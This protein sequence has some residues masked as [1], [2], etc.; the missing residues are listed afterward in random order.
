MKFEPYNSYRNC[1]FPLI[2]LIPENWCEQKIKFQLSGCVAGGTPESGNSLFWEESGEGTPWVSIAD[3]TRT[4]VVTETE[5]DVSDKGIYAKGLKIV[6]K[7]TLLYS[8]FASLGKV[9]EA[10]ADLTT[11]QAILA[12]IPKETLNNRF[13]RYWLQSI[14]NYLMYYSTSNTQNNLNSEK[15]KNLPVFVPSDLEQEK[16]ANFLD[17]ETAKID[18]LIEK[19]Q[20]LIRLLKEK[21]QAVISHAVTKGLSSLKGGPKAKM[22]D[23]GVEWLGEVPEHWGV[24]KVKWIVE[25][26]GRIGYRGYTVDDIVDEGDGAIVL[27]PSNINE[28][29]FSLEKKVFLSWGKY[30]ESPEIMLEPGDILLVKTSWSFG[31]VA[32]VFEVPSPMTINPQ[33]VLLKKSKIDSRYVSQFLGTD[34]LQA[35]IFMINTGSYMPTMTQENIGELPILV[36]PESEAIEIASFIQARCIKFNALLDKQE[37]VVDLLQER[38]AALI[39]AAVTGKID[40][41]GWVAP[42]S[43]Q[44]NKEV[45]A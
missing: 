40:V 6:P 15:V 28:R 5:K 12:L 30:F 24:S 32:V 7:G 16:I 44:T 38:R 4:A 42:G 37:D 41:R 20:Q 1:N 36:P 10:G 45:A 18:T 9:A 35:R 3:M 25:M 2:D 11:N 43:A 19:Q 13:F 27:S 23:S 33:M 26:A 14:E 31:K 17:H 29:G 8:I 34:A 39:S 22:R 21:R